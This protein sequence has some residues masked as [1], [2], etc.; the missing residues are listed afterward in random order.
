MDI[1]KAVK[2]LSELEDADEIDI[3]VEEKEACQL[4]IEA[5]KWLQYRRAKGYDYLGHLLPGETAS[6][7]CRDI[8]PIEE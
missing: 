5:L 3:T 6:E 4:G 1:N 8:Q 2:I 7:V